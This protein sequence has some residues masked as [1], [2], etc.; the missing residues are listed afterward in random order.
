MP[1]GSVLSVKDT[2]ILLTGALWLSVLSVTDFSTMITSVTR[3]DLNMENFGLNIENFGLWLPL[4]PLKE[5]KYDNVLSTDNIDESKVMDVDIILRILVM[6][7][8]RQSLKQSLL[9]I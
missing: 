5:P 6:L 8:L 4:V 7:W 3:S 9:Q 1:D 2:D